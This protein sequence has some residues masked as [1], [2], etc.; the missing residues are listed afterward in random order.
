VI[1]VVSG[2]AG[3]SKE[4]AEYDLVSS[5]RTG[6]AESVI[7]TFDPAQVSYERLLEVFFTVAHDPTQLN[8]QG[9]DIGPQYRSAIF[10]ADTS[11]RRAARAMI[12]RLSGARAFTRP[13]VTQILPLDAFYPA[14]EY[15]QDFAARYP[16]HPY[17]VMH[18]APKVA[19][20]K[21]SYPTLYRSGRP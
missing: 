5:G 7:V 9:P 8:H 1:D 19:Q 16:D 4:T 3:G 15:H 12:E 6:H 20:L 18:D 14:E 2:Y 21:A 10:V 17:I 11:Q 13:I